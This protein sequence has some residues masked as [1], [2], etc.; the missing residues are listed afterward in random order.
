MS[1]KIQP[2]RRGCGKLKIER[3]P[4]SYTFVVKRVRVVRFVKV[5]VPLSLLVVLFGIPLVI[6][7][8]HMLINV[9]KIGVVSK[10]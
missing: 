1:W 3:I 2:A 9:A 4:L 7:C 10:I 5:V 6:L 8:S